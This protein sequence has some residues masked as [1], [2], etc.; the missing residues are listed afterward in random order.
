MPLVLSGAAVS[1]VHD[2]CLNAGVPGVVHWELTRPDGFFGCGWGHLKEMSPQD[3]R[4]S[5][6]SAS[7]GEYDSVSSGNTHYFG[8]PPL[9]KGAKC[10]SEKENR[11]DGSNAIELSL[12]HS[13]LL[14]DLLDETSSEQPLH[15]A[16]MDTVADAVTHPSGLP[17]IPAAPLTT[18]CGLFSSD[19]TWIN[20][21]P[22]SAARK[23][24]VPTLKNSVGSHLS[25]P[26]VAPVGGLTAS[27]NTEASLADWTRMTMRALSH[28]LAGTTQ[29][30]GPRSSLPRRA[31][32][33]CRPRHSITQL[34][35][36]LTRDT[37]D[38]SAA[39]SDTHLTATVKRPEV[40]AIPLDWHSVEG[41]GTDPLVPQLANGRALNRGD[42][43]S[44]TR[45]TA[46]FR[47]SG[48]RPCCR[49]PLAVG[50]SPLSSP[51]EGGPGEAS[52]LA[53]R[54]H[55]GGPTAAAAWLKSAV[56]DSP[57]RRHR[58]DC[59]SS[60]HHHVSQG[61]PHELNLNRDTL[62]D[63]HRNSSQ[64]CSLRDM[65]NDVR[66]SAIKSAQEWPPRTGDDV[67]RL[68][69]RL[70]AEELLRHLTVV[71]FSRKDPEGVLQ[72]FES[73]KR[74]RI[75]PPDAQFGV[76]YWYTMKRKNER[77]C[78]KHNGSGPSAEPRRGCDYAL[79]GAHRKCRYPH[80]CLFCGAGD[81]GWVEEERCN[82]YLSLQGE[83]KRLGVTNDVALIL[84][85]AL[86]CGE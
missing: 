5:S 22:P 35:A 77:L 41:K 68:L 56:M 15:A 42:G 59:Q 20:E 7:P 46:S 32:P 81:H 49:P 21:C 51:R 3:A 63:L 85:D 65:M 61:P 45:S 13:G 29:G 71:S 60:Y 10:A 30:E 25:P 75:F 26:L 72:L 36:Q 58:S 11:C 8:G 17:Q 31:P 6:S 67:S 33:C 2:H 14:D 23:T 50:C 73:W 38:T 44:G 70:Y 34:M 27:C 76:Y 79:R 62:S 66:F 43:S 1:Q 78:L 28:P 64:V 12:L 9:C 53:E 86:E 18:L 37:N 39:T 16:T 4:R 48:R 84:L 55:D 57:R 52:V 83:M 82:R 54:D 74:K 80:K 47:D 40:K 19:R 24:P 69:K